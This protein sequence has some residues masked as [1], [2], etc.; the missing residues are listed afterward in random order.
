[1][2][3]VKPTD[4][5]SIALRR[6]IFFGHL[7]DSMTK[8]ILSACKRET[9]PK[10]RSLISQDFQG[11]LYFIVS[12]QVKSQR[13][14]A[15]TGRSVTLFMFGPGDIFDVL[16]LLHGAPDESVFEACNDVSLLSVPQDEVRRWIT[17]YPDFNRAIL[18]YL[19]RMIT[20]LEDQAADLVLYDTETR[21]AHLI[22]RHLEPQAHGGFR[23]IDEM[24]HENM[25]QMIGS[26]RTVVNRQLKYWRQKGIISTDNGKIT[27]KRLESLL[28]K[29]ER[30]LPWINHR[31]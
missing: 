3:A 26:V 8:S 13:I 21:L 18:P 20:H 29:T 28:E 27:V 15:D 23:L 2:T 4:K 30:H 31:S 10:G 12:G 1:M 9:W 14:N 17:C 25:A 7:D 19:G 16:Q 11:K 22:T 6:S 24:T 5:V